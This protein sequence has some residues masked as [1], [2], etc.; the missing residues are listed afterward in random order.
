M[1]YRVSIV[2]FNIDWCLRGWRHDDLSV[3]WDSTCAGKERR[4]I[5]L[6]KVLPISTGDDH[7]R[8][9]EC[10]IVDLP[11]SCHVAFDAFHSSAG[12]Q[13]TVTFEPYLTI[14]WKQFYL[15]KRFVQEADSFH[16]FESL[17]RSAGGAGGVCLFNENTHTA[18]LLEWI[19]VI[20]SAIF[21]VKNWF[22]NSTLIPCRSST[23]CR[24]FRPWVT[25]PNLNIDWCLRVGRHEHLSVGWGATCAG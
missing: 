3:C 23:K 16:P 17:H 21:F 1:T 6:R 19:Y 8:V 4:R 22:C 18:V 25:I 10:G 5:K 11:L 15:T 13:G 2:N 12:G 7:D 14:L 24:F 20:S 9:G